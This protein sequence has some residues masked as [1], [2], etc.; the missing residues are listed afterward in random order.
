MNILLQKA[1]KTSP[2]VQNIIGD[3][4]RK[5]TIFALICLFALLLLFTYFYKDKKQNENDITKLNQNSAD[6]MLIYENGTVN[7]YKN[8][9]LIRNYESIEVAELPLTDRDNL[10]SGIK[11]KTIDEVRQIIEDFDGNY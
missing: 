11:I 4:M 9:E 7:L 6:Y 8:N 1:Y 3:F 10:S 5:Y 2:S